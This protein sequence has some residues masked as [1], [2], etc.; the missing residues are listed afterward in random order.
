MCG[1]VGAVSKK[2]VVSI[3]VEGLRRL[4]IVATILVA[5]LY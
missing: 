1:I 2:N 3:L 4:R 5:L